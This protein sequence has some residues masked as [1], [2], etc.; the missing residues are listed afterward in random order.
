MEPTYQSMSQAGG[1]EGSLSYQKGTETNQNPPVSLLTLPVELLHI[2]ME[3]SPTEDALRL[4][5]TCRR[6]HECLWERFVRV[7][8]RETWMAQCLVY[9]ACIFDNRRLLELML[10]RDDTVL[11]E[12]NTDHWPESCLATHMIPEAFVPHRHDVFF[13][14]EDRVT[15]LHYAVMAG[16][17]DIVRF[18]LDQS[19]D[20]NIRDDLWRTPLGHAFSE[21]MIS[22]LL[23]AGAL[24]LLPYYYPQEREE[25][26]PRLLDDQNCLRWNALSCFL[27][28]PCLW[29]VEETDPP[30]RTVAGFRRL[31]EAAFLQDPDWDVNKEVM[32]NSM[33][34]ISLLNRAIAAGPEFVRCLLELGADPNAMTIGEAPEIVDNSSDFSITFDERPYPTE[35]KVK[36]RPLHQIYHYGCPRKLDH[37]KTLLEFGARINDIV[38]GETV[39]TQAIAEG[40]HDIVRWLVEE[41]GADPNMIIPYPDGELSM[42]HNCPDID[43]FRN[44]LY[45]AIEKYR[46]TKMVEVLVSVGAE[47]D[48]VVTRYEMAKLFGLRIHRYHRR[49]GWE[50]LDELLEIANVLVKGG[51]DPF[52]GIQ[53]TSYELKHPPRSKVAPIVTLRAHIHQTRSRAT[54]DINSVSVR[55]VFEPVLGHHRFVTLSNDSTDIQKKKLSSIFDLDLSKLGV[56]QH[57]KNWCLLHEAMM[58]YRPKYVR[59]MLETGMDPLCK[60]RLSSQMRNTPLGVLINARNFCYKSYGCVGPWTK[61]DRIKAWLFVQHCDGAAMAKFPRG[62]MAMFLAHWVARLGGVET[63]LEEIREFAEMTNHNGRWGPD[64]ISGLRELVEHPAYW[65]MFLRD[66]S[67]GGWWARG[68]P[69]WD[70]GDNLLRAARTIT[71]L[72][73]G[74]SKSEES[75]WCWARKWRETEPRKQRRWPLPV[76]E[77]EVSFA[78][79][80]REDGYEE[81]LHRWSKNRRRR[82]RR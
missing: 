29:R 40:D 76:S 63:Q 31:L 17:I 77:Y 4:L 48:A 59:G 32:H 44:A 6:L 60:L 70:I 28:G 37:F 62:L 5:R 8:T 78:V 73:G 66:S 71:G 35:L 65:C 72:A 16:N 36:S 51:I 15:P 7:R 80:Y 53:R 42:S 82:G 54:N 22:L 1:D 3:F 74:T 75:Y 33:E 11:N 49:T 21:D 2:I 9:Y 46:D 14:F 52:C 67:R 12:I 43:S 19:V 64:G 56:G 24:P 58:Y 45:D 55:M 26:V 34:S 10:E 81:K 41:G 25:W 79:L 57:H 61:N 39:L 38:C 27:T 69:Y 23:D 13:R 68:E 18:L 30:K 50:K 47:L 20:V